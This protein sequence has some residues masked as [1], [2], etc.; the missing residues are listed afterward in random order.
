MRTFK[1]AFFTLTFIFTIRLSDLPAQDTNYVKR[2][3]NIVNLKTFIYNNGL[4]FQ[5][6]SSGLSYI[7]GLHSGVGIGVY[8]KYIPFDFSI[9]QEMSSLREDSRY[10]KVKTTDMQLKGYS[11]FFAGDIFIQK[12]TGFYTQEDFSYKYLYK[13]NDSLEFEPDLS[14]FQFEAVGKYIFNYERFT[15]KAGCTAYERQKISAGSFMAGA[16][17]HYL[18][19]NSDSR[20]ISIDNSSFLKT[21]NFGLNCGYAYNFVFGKRSNFF[22]S[23]L[24]G[25]NIS[26][27]LSKTISR[28]DITFSPS[29]HLKSAYWINFEDWSAGIT[30]IYNIIHQT[31][32]KDLTIFLH[33]HKFEIL[34][35]RRLCY[36]N[37]KKNE[38]DI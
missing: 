26:N 5:D 20:L 33:T 7:P 21:S 23:A 32:N 8:C 14:I 1:L 25:I 15:Y 29:V 24:P 34:L 36:K 12:Y 38:K 2:Y 13:D 27:P 10:H 3:G 6:K 35:I 4:D 37:L 31:F 16:S 30:G 9:R 22:V 17:F 11:K 18:K 19:I 28:E